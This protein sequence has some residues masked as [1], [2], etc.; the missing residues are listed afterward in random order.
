MNG[1]WNVKKLF[2]AI[3]MVILSYG[4]AQGGEVY[5]MLDSSLM[6]WGEKTT[7]EDWEYDPSVH[8]E[9]PALQVGDDER[10]WAM[11]PVCYLMYLDIGPTAS[12]A[13][14]GLFQILQWEYLDLTFWFKDGEGDLFLRGLKDDEVLVDIHFYPTE[15]GTYVT[16]Y[17]YDR[18]L[19]E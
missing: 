5:A 14:E 19:G 16:L 3:V 17:Y 2:A 12:V 7:C 1:G 11:F 8:T 4:F 15:N 9:T 6:E 18:I 13:N 10:G